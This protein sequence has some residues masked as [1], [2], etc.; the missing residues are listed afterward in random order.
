M[1]FEPGYKP[2]GPFPIQ[3]QLDSTVLELL[4]I[5]YYYKP[6]RD[7]RYINLWTTGSTTPCLYIDLSEYAF[8]IIAMADDPLKPIKYPWLGKDLQCS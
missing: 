5:T 6:N 7:D 3:R 8:K 2:Y 1:E 4:D